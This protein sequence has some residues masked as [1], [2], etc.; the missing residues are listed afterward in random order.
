MHQPLKRMPFAGIWSSDS[1]TLLFSGVLILLAVSACSGIPISYYD[2]TTY[3]RLTSLKA[4]T[5]LLI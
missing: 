2:D 5:M 4:E 3:T 1:I